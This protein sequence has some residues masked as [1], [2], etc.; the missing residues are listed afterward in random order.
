MKEEWK[1]LYEFK[2]GDCAVYN[3]GELMLKQLPDLISVMPKR[4]KNEVF[5]W[6]L[7]RFKKEVFKWMLDR[8]YY[9]ERREVQRR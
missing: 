7:K 4:F 8:E 6:M 1:E 9:R 3:G 2:N 5:K